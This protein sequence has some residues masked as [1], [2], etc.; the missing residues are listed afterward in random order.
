M[1]DADYMQTTSA[2][3]GSGEKALL[4]GLVLMTLYLG[5]DGFTST[6]QSKLFKGYQTSVTNQSMY[7]TAFSAGFAFLGGL[8]IVYTL[9]CPFNALFC[10][11]RT[12][13]P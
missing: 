7:T 8:P 13:A 3:G 5:F 4:H 1:A 2:F 6:F 11:N 10:R 12:A 9:S